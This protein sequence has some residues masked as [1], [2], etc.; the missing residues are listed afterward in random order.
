M[1]VRQIENTQSTI[2][3][4]TVEGDE[5]IVLT[6]IAECGG[7]YAVHYEDSGR[8]IAGHYV[9]QENKQELYEESE[10]DQFSANDSEWL[11]IP[12]GD[13]TKWSELS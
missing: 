6:I 12:N 9:D 5:T 7:C 3:V 4:K 8:E 11:V 13:G 1:H 10:D 2:T